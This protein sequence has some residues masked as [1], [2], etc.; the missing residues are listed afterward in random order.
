MA[1]TAAQ[2]AEYA[3]L[4]RRAL[5]AGIAPP[6]AKPSNSEDAKALRELAAAIL[7]LAESRSEPAPA[8]P[9]PAAA[10]RKWKFSHKYDVHGR[11]TE[12]HAEQV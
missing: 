6:P 8:H 7:K 1:L 4:A 11:V 10:P 3:R 12:T 5:K 2:E 9:T